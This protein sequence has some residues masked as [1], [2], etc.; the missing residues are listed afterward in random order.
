MI[1]VIGAGALWYLTRGTGLVALVLLTASVVLGVLSSVR[2]RS[3]NLPRFVTA[4]LH[5]NISLLAVYF[6]A[7]HVVTAVADGYAPIRWLD[8]VVPFSS[9]YRPVWLGLGAVAVDLLVA[10]TITSMLRQRLGY[11][12]WRAV[13]WASYACWPAALVHGFG[14]GTD[15]RIGWALAVQLACLAVVVGAVWWRLATATG[16]GSAQRATAAAASVMLPLIILAWLVLGPMRPGWASRAGT[17]ASLL[18]PTAGST[19]AGGG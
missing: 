6:V 13:H 15:T 11:R 3:R 7:A 5:G 1:A 4:A 19:S 16:L 2:W 12:A 9:P 17:P 18:R 14:T 10:V 8:T